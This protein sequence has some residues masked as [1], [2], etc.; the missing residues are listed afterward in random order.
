MIKMIVEGIRDANLNDR[1][2]VDLNAIF[3]RNLGMQH[4][5]GKV[6]IGGEK[7]L[8]GVIIGYNTNLNEKMVIK[9]QHSNIPDFKTIGGSWEWKCAGLSGPYWLNFD[10]KQYIKNPRG[11]NNKTLM[12]IMV[13]K[14]NQDIISN[15]DKENK[16]IDF[17]NCIITTEKELKDLEFRLE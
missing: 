4:M 7:M 10:Y 3:G 6:E 13:H 1:Y 11:N 9:S 5:C 14:D 12:T 2:S 17:I 8:L 16:V 15:Y